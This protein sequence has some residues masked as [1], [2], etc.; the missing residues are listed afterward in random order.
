M[1]VLK[2]ETLNT[3]YDKTESRIK[4]LH[5]YRQLLISIKTFEDFSLYKLK[6]T[7]FFF[8]IEDDLR[9]SLQNSKCAYIE[10]KELTND[11]HNIN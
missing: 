10:I 6:F 7:Q 8:D 2:T 4:D 11:Y 1:Q 3:L 9:E 5:S